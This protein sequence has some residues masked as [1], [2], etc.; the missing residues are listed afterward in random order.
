MTLPQRLLNDNHLLHTHIGRL[1][2]EIQ[3]VEMEYIT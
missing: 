3:R 2:L 1:R